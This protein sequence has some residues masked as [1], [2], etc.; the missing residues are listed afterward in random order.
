MDR[1]RFDGLF[2]R[3]VAR[4]ANVTAGTTVGEL[5]GLVSA[6]E[7]TINKPCRLW[8]GSSVLSRMKSVAAWLAPQ[9]ARPPDSSGSFR[10]GRYGPSLLN[11]SG[12][13]W[14]R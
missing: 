5:G 11:P 13:V 6:W 3:W 7:R 9:A 8:D 14:V 2:R 10:N 12:L 1:G 4:Q